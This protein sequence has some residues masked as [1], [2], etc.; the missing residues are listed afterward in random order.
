MPYF[1]PFLFTDPIIYPESRSRV[2]YIEIAVRFKG[3]QKAV[4]NIQFATNQLLV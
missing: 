1:K 3:K 4:V 2:K